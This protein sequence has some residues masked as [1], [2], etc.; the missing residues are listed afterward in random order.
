MLITSVSRKVWLV[1]LFRAAI[2]SLKIAGNVVAVDI[3][4]LSAGLFVGDKYY[5]VPPVSNDHFTKNILEICHK[6]QISLV[7]PTRDAELAFFAENKDIFES[8]G[9]RILVSKKE[10]I[11]ICRDKYLFYK[12]LE[13]N[14]FV[15]TETYLSGQRGPSLKFPVIVKPRCGSGGKDVF[16][17]ENLYELKFFEKYVPNAI[18]QSFIKGKEYTVDVF[19]DFEGNV[20][21]VVPRERIEIFGG[22]SFKGRTVKND[23]IMN[24][25]KKLAEKLGSVGHITIQCI[26]NEENLFFIEV[27]PRFGGGAALSIAAGANTPALILRLL[28]NEKVK[29]LIGQYE[30]GL[31]M[32]RYTEDFF[33]NEKSLK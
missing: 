5:L 9:V 27:N 29:P 19:S 33:I 24:Q 10:V 20:L 14:G 25:A 8:N 23:L 16:K 3:N 26:V 17:A 30:E 1:K 4:P 11:E 2:K 18:L 22:E 13:E 12:F 32:L 15:V 7:V 31:I 21:S 28:M 6:E